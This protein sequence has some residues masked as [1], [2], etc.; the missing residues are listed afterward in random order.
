[1]ISRGYAV[2]GQL[3]VCINNRYIKRKIGVWARHHLT[4]KRI[5]VHVNQCWR[6]DLSARIN[7]F[8]LNWATDLNYRGIVNRNGSFYNLS[9]QENLCTNKSPYH[10][11]RSK[12]R[13]QCQEPGLSCSRSSMEITSKP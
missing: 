10:D 11:C 4:F 12:I 3:S 7:H 8:T 5:P 1:M 13:C 2:A 9:G 6:K